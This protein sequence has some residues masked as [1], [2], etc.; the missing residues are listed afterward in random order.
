MANAIKIV[1]VILCLL[2]LADMPYGFYQLVRFFA[3]IGFG[4]LA[5]EAYKRSE[6]NTTFIYLALAILFQPIFKISLGRQ[7]W[8]IVDVIVAI[9]LVLTLF[10][11][12]KNK[13]F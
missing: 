3:L 8:N 13:T 1:L 5:F 12:N 9:G 2:C 6:Q 11:S 7:V 4:F 10:I